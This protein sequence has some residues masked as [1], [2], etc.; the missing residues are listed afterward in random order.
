MTIAANAIEP[1]ETLNALVE[2]FPAALPVLREFGLDTCC[3]GALTLPQ[4]AAHHGIDLGQ[5]L[6]AL[7]RAQEAAETQP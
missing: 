5:L 3:G 4:A 2:R 1:S 7:R 6:E